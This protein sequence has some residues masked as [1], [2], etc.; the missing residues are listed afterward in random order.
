V[1]ALA[2][3]DEYLTKLG[4]PREKIPV[5]KAASVGIGAGRMVDMWPSSPL[6]GVAPT[7]GVA[8]TNATAGSLLQ[9]D[10]GTE[11][12]F[13]MGGELGF[14]NGTAI[15]CDR[16]SHQ[17]GLSG[18]VTTVDVTTNLPTAALTRYTTG[19]DVH[20][21]ITVYG[22]I[23]GT[24]TTITCKYTNQAGTG[25][26]VTPLRVIG[27][28]GFREVQ[29]F[30]PIPLA[31][32]DTGIRSVESS[33][34]TATTGTAGNFGYTLYKPLVAFSVD[35]QNSNVFFNILDGGMSGGMPEIM[36]GAC[37]F[38]LMTAAASGAV[39]VNGS[40]RLSAV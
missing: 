33:T 14:A 20:L 28:S 32:G 21:G 19:A 5:A 8:P 10:G 30:L 26:Q 40:L 24:G 34:L 18:T 38:W 37:L 29:R 3:F 1:A 9:Q 11:Q 16:L 27:G 15:L 12:T 39:S 36:D 25:G 17:G 2:D 23:G 6:P 22:L 35:R 4:A 7:T 31:S 13:M